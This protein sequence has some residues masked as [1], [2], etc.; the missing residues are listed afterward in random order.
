MGIGI[1]IGIGGRPGRPRR[2]GGF[3]IPAL[4]TDQTGL[5]SDNRDPAVRFTD[6]GGT[7]PAGVGEGVA[8]R[9]DKSRGLV[10]GPELVANGGPSFVNTASITATNAA[11]SVVGGRL[12]ITRTSAGS[13]ASWSF[14]VVAG[15]VYEITATVNSRSDG[16]GAGFNV[17][18]V[19]AST[20]LDSNSFSGAYP[21]T[22]KIRH[23]ASATGTRW[24][25]I[26]ASSVDG[27]TCD[28]TSIQVREIFGNHS[29]QSSPSFRPV[30]SA[31]GLLY[32]G[33]DDRL[34]TTFNPTLSGS[35]IARFNGTQASRVIMGSAASSNGRA[36][37]GLD[38]SGRLAAGIGEQNSTTIFGGADI[39]NAWRI[40]C[41]TWDG[42][43]VRLYLDGAEIYSGAQ[44]GAVNT[45][46]PMMEGALNANGTAGAFFAGTISDAL[47]LSRVLTPAEI[48]NLTNQWSA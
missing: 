43:T 19:A 34:L 22:R 40:G 21:E 48:V 7:I 33:S 2:G 46:V 23:T 44:V 26:F 27:G 47:A 42:T 36:W 12:R 10:L 6:A 18:A 13:A 9:L 39:R 17:S 38:A 31:N 14:P 5:W 37:L 15:R 24:V 41:V 30:V 8:L 16:A 4:F 32:D 28:V 1:G 29:R 20:G 25:N 35:I 45:T 11:L 3:S